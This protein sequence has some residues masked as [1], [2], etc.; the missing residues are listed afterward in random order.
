MNV[1]WFIIGRRTPSYSFSLKYHEVTFVEIKLMELK[2]MSNVIII[3]NISVMIIVND[4]NTYIW[5]SSISQNLFRV[6]C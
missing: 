5:L 3:G 1:N 4:K 6:G 2:N